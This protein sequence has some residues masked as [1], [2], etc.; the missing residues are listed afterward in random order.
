MP[1]RRGRIAEA[2]TLPQMKA[3]T[4]YDMVISIYGLQLQSFATVL[5][6]FICLMH[7]VMPSIFCHALYIYM[8]D[9]YMLF[10]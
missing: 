3:A 2:T 10:P 4:V 9:E 7:A 5:F 6:M 8:R 1:S